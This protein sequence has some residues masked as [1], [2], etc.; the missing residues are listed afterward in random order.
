[1]QSRFVQLKFRITRHFLCPRFVAGKAAKPEDDPAGLDSVSEWTPARHHRTQEP[2]QRVC[3]SEY[4]HRSARALQKDAALPVR[5]EHAAGG[6][7]RATDTS[8]GDIC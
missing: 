3:G 5:A 4:G 2:G 8:K 6:K 1:V 7:R